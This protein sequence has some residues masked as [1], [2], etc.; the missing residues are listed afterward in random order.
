M[1]IPASAKAMAFIATRDRRKAKSF[2]GDT[3]G[4]ALM[5]EDDFAPVFDLNGTKLRISEVADHA[6]L[7]YTVLGWE[8]ADIAETAKALWSKG[9]SFNRYDG[10][11]QDELG[12]WTA[13]G[14]AAKVVWFTDPDGNV[15]SLTQF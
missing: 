8:V 15:L 12:V 10:L 13:P 4:F 5:Q 11:V 6:P 9:I 7:P 2:Y 1:S 14:G 3:L